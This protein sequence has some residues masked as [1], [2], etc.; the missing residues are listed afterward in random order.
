MKNSC[1]DY[2][3]TI[4][5]LPDH[6]ETPLSD[7]LALHLDECAPCRTLFDG[8]RVP[9]D[10]ESFEVLAP[11]SRKRILQALAAVRSQPR[12]RIPLLAATAGLAAIGFVAALFVSEFQAHN[13]GQEV[14]AN[15][16]QDHIRYLTHPDRQTD[17]DLAQIKNY[18]DAYVDFPIE[19]LESPGTRLTGMRRCFLVD[20]RAALAFYDTPA[21]PASYFIVPGEGLRIPGSQCAGDAH[22]Y[23]AAS[24]GYR[25]VSWEEA[26]LLHAVVGSDE[27]SLLDMARAAVSGTGPLSDEEEG[28]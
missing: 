4:Q 23:C 10:L 22:L 9:F 2:Q 1:G 21:G 5:R 24:H 16:V 26:G 3:E 28:S 14:A 15:I 27:A 12:G 25:M 13:K 7:D 11:A 19:F 8:S 18:L 6:L 17:A 20:R